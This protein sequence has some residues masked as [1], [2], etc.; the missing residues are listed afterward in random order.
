DPR[1]LE[2]VAPGVPVLGVEFVWGVVAEGALTAQDLLERRT[3]LSLVDAWGEVARAAAE[4][5][6]QA[7][8]SD[9]P[10]VS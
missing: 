6:L 10:L 8:G 1:L 4:T 7:A 9:R 2:P 5:A 3:R